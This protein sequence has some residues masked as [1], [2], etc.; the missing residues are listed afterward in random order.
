MHCI[1][2]YLTIEELYIQKCQ[3]AL[4][5]V[6]VASHLLQLNSELT[7][8][9]YAPQTHCLLLSISWEV[10]PQIWYKEWISE[11]FIQKFFK[12]EAGRERKEGVERVTHLVM[13]S[14]EDWLKTAHRNWETGSQVLDLNYVEHRHMLLLLAIDCFGLD[15]WF[16]RKIHSFCNAP[17]WRGNVFIKFIKFNG[18]KSTSN[19]V[20]HISEAE[21]N[22]CI[23]QKYILSLREFN[24][25]A[26]VQLYHHPLSSKT[27]DWSTFIL[28]T[29]EVL[30]LLLPYLIWIILLEPIRT[31]VG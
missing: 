19:S 10:Q 17:V 15:S 26:S 2:W 1:V 25:S 12:V 5:V 14:A 24:P 28:G 21:R 22:H 11:T 29:V 13:L 9:C 20:I 18:W 6:K 23:L 27:E 16:L 4:K 3:K 31:Q 8:S 30:L 7:K